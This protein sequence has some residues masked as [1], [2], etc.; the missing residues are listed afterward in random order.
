[1][2]QICH[3]TTHCE[4]IIKAKL[5]EN[6]EQWDKIEEKNNYKGDQSQNA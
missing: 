6:K 5:G 4:N 3:R 2:K 1:M